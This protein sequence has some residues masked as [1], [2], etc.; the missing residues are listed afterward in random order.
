MPNDSPLPGSW[1]VPGPDPRGYA[2][3]QRQF[4]TWCRLRSLPLFAVRRADIEG[5]ARDLDARAARR[6]GGQ[7]TVV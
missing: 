3:D 6:R 7:M 4:T 2:L 5:S 1:P